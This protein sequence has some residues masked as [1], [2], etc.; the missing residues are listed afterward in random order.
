MGWWVGCTVKDQKG[1]LV[2]LMTYEFPLS[3]SQSR[4]PIHVFGVEIIGHED[5]QSSA[6]TVCQVHSDQWA[7]R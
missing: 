2:G 1:F 6:E 7:G 3:G 5:R 4:V